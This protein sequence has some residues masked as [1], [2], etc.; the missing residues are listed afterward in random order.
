M[1]K[2][3]GCPATSGL[4]L[5]PACNTLQKGRFVIFVTVCQANMNK[6]ERAQ[7]GQSTNNWQKPQWQKK[8]HLSISVTFFVQIDVLRLRQHHWPTARRSW[9]QDLAGAGSLHVLPVS[10]LFISGYSSL[11]VSPVMNWRRSPSVSWDRLQPPVTQKR[12]SIVIFFYNK[13]NKV[14]R[15][16]FEAGKVAGSRYKQ[17]LKLLPIK[18]SLTLKTVCLLGLFRFVFLFFFKKSIN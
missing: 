2:I 12:I 1:S 16:L 14:P 15:T 11:S 4:I 8:A 3:A 18:V 7:T 17:S 5:Q 10:A 6:V 9:V 13:E